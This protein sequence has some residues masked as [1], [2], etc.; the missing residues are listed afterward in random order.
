MYVV[1]NGT[2]VHCVRVNWNFG[3]MVGRMLTV[4]DED[5]REQD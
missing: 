5:R 4:L 2:G 1:V 3:E